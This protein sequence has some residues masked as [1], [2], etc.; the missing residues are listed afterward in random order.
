MVV[1]ILQDNSF[2]NS[3]RKKKKKK[4]SKKYLM[5]KVISYNE[6][7]VNKFHKISNSMLKMG[8]NS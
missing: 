1:R 3:K 6:N 5:I 2:Q 4:I 8:Q 7:C